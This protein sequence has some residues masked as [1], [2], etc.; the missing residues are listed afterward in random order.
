M[1]LRL[2]LLIKKD[3]YYLKSIYLFV[4]I[5]LFL[6]KKVGFARF[7][8]QHLP[9]MSEDNIIVHQF[10]EKRTFSRCWR[11]A[12]RLIIRLVR[13]ATVVTSMSLKLPESAKGLSSNW[14]LKHV[15]S[16]WFQ[17][18]VPTES[19]VSSPPFILFRGGHVITLLI[20]SSLRK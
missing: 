3:I 1:T 14:T 15:W 11:Y 16:V 2:N 8:P 18:W 5:K 6:I 4:F 19:S 20:W 13:S 12:W 10:V 7:A 9:S 17:R